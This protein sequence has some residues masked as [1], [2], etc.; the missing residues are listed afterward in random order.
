MCGLRRAI[1][2]CLGLGGIFL[3][4][5]LMAAG[6]GAVLAA[7]ADKSASIVMQV[8]ALVALLAVLVDA[9]LLLI[10]VAIVSARADQPAGDQTVG[11]DS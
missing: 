10:L 3:A 1:R 7:A 11:D 9:V 8:I 2:R 6:L 5:M 4:T